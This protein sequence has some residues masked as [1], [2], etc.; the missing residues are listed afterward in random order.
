MSFNEQSIEDVLYPKIDAH[1]TGILE[2]TEL[3]TIAWERAGNPDGM[4][5]IVIHGGPGGGSQ[6]SYRQYFDPEFF[7]IIQFD[8]RGCG[9][10]TPYAE[11]TDN[12]TMAS[13]SDIESLR[14]HLGIERWHVF[15]GSWG[16]TLSLIYAENHPERALSLILRGIFICRKDSRGDWGVCGGIRV[17]I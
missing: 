10:S 13:V 4:P 6:P 3:H 14:E 15:G 17:G 7:D 11:L 9:Q 5:V 12:N 8:Q 16:S 2:V 1:T